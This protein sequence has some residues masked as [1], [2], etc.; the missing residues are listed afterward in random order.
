M[1]FVGS[2]GATLRTPVKFFD[3]RERP[4]IATVGLWVE[5]HVPVKAPTT[6]AAKTTLWFLSTTKPMPEINIPHVSGTTAGEAMPSFVLAIIDLG[7]KAI[8]G[9]LFGTG[10][11]VAVDGNV[12][13]SCMPAMCSLL[14]R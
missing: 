3:V 4:L 1:E 11:V 7:E 10:L 12:W 13:D 9:T 2:Y 8:Q 14:A 5:F 6:G